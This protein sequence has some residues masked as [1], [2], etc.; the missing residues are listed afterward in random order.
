MDLDEHGG[1]SWLDSLGIAGKEKEDLHTINGS[2]Q[3]RE[4]VER[5]RTYEARLGWDVGN[6]K[7]ISRRL[8]DK[9]DRGKHDSRRFGW[10]TVAR[11]RQ[12][13]RGIASGSF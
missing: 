7:A 5:W 2:A 13:H 12:I 10:L 1:H 9:E 6:Y 8:S 11:Y 3:V 4:T